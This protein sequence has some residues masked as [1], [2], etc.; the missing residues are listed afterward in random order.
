MARCGCAGTSCSCVLQAGAGITVDGAGTETNPYIISGGE[1][2]GGGVLTVLDTQTVDLSLLGAGTT[3]SPYILSANA[4]LALDEL[5]DVTATDPVDGY[6][7]AWNGTAWQPIP[8]TT[9]PIGA[10]AVGDGLLGDGSA[11]DPIRLDPAA[12]SGFV[13]PTGTVV[14]FAGTTTPTGYLP[15]NDTPVGRAAFA[16]L[17]AVI[18]TTYGAGN[19]TTTFNVPNMVSRAAVGAGVFDLGTP[20][21]NATHTHSTPA[22]T[23]PV[24][25]HTHEVPAHEHELGA[26]GRAQIT[27]AQDE[28]FMRRVSTTAWNANIRT[29][30]NL[31]NGSSL[32]T[33]N[34]GAP[35]DGTT[36][37]AGPWETGP[38]G[39]GSTGSGGA[40]TTGATTSLPP[41]LPLNYIIKT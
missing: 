16:D 10:I 39:A 34:F 6:V 40:G 33:N 36:G 19:G 9:A 25:S 28:I 13:V 21:G 26:D 32:V 27:L 1:G 22:H 15:C 12:I 20:V 24:V 4:T 31:N 14:P 2:G 8:P 3:A 7:L 37:F 35:L 23:H 18:G 5:V 11:G 38:G 30:T 17:F 41:S 29:N